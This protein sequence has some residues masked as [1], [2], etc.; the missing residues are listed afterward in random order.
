M[1]FICLIPEPQDSNPNP[2][3]RSQ[4]NRA[5]VIRNQSFASAAIAA[6]RLFGIAIDHYAMKHRMM[7]AADFVLEEENVAI[8]L[9]VDDVLEA[10][11]MIAHVFSNKAAFFEEIVGT[12]KVCVVDRACKQGVSSNALVN[13]WLEPKIK[14]E[15]TT[16]VGR[17]LSAKNA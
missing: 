16:R 13:L 4:N 10:K 6:R 7:H 5:S 2:S 17:K 12:G 9:R 8:A 15:R 14:E 11:L 1:K 3:E